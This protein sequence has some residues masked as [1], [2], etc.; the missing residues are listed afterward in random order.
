MSAKT[1]TSS[2]H[3]SEA[4]CRESLLSQMENHFPLAT[5]EA[6]LKT[7]RHI[8]ELHR[9]HIG[10]PSDETI[11][12]WKELLDITARDAMLSK[13]DKMPFLIRHVGSEGRKERF[14]RGRESAYLSGTCGREG[15]TEVDC[16]TDVLE[17][18]TDAAKGKKGSSSILAVTKK[19]GIMATPEGVNYMMKLVGP[20]GLK[21]IMSLDQDHKK[22]LEDAS[23]ALKIPVKEFIQITM[24]PGKKGREINCYFLDAAMKAGLRVENIISIDS[25]DFM[26]SVVAAM[27]NSKKFERPIIVVGRGGFEEGTIAASAVKTLGGFMEARQFDKDPK[28]M[29]NNPLWTIEDL[30]PAKHHEILTSI[31]FVTKND[32]WFNKPG[33]INNVITNLIITH[34]GPRFEEIPLQ[35]I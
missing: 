9:N 10:A 19:D 5:A 2:I 11:E 3:P 35:L 8:R 26:P 18:T 7:H 22:N 4:N 16:V 33:A 12:E 30:V 20:A 34:K 15:Y 21:G 23:K 6:A 31:S 17:Q 13:M 27:S 1:E 32:R 25:G 14:Y 28:K 29:N 24:N